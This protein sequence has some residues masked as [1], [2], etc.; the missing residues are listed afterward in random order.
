MSTHLTNG[1]LAAAIAAGVGA[2]AVFTWSCKSSSAR[3]PP[4]PKGYPL[5]GSLLSW[6]S[7]QEWFTFTKWRDEFGDIVYA[8]VA[9]T[10]IVVLNSPAVAKAL[11]D[12]RG[13]IYSDRPHLH[14]AN[15]IIGWKDSPIMCLASHPYFKPSRRM[16]LGAVGSR[17]ALESYIHLEEHEVHRFLRRVIDEPDKVEYYLRKWV[18]RRPSGSAC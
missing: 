6:P 13:A 18:L 15:D 2:L 17:A 5:I 4:G 3:L 8:N 14:F 7:G 9:G 1:Q 10:K 11:L 12:D 16:M